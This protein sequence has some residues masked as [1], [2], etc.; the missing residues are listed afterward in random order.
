MLNG[1]A[2]EKGKSSV[3]KQVVWVKTKS[4]YEREIK[5]ELLS[6]RSWWQPSKLLL[7]S[8]LITENQ[9]DIRF[10]EF[11]K[12]TLCCFPSAAFS[13]LMFSLISCKWMMFLIIPRSSVSF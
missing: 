6:H 8:S 5:A 4:H 2:S 11:E 7:L 12:V 13:Q 10:Y 3:Q 9:P 1:T